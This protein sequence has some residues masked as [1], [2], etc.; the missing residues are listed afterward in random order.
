MKK[1]RGHEAIRT[2]VD[3]LSGNTD[4][5]AIMTLFLCHIR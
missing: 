1:G 3:A 4:D 2:C 5:H